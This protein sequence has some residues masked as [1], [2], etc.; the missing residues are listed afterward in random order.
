MASKDKTTG[1]WIAQWYEI[2]VYGKKKRHK[3]EV[4]VQCVKPSSMKVRQS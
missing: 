3:K 1:L 2:D 4:F